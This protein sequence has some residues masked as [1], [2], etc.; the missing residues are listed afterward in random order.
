LNNYKVLEIIE[1]LMSFGA[2]NTPDGHKITPLEWLRFKTTGIILDKAKNYYGHKSRENIYIFSYLPLSIPK[3]TEI[4]SN[5][6]NSTLPNEKTSKHKPRYLC[7]SC[8]CIF[9]NLHEI[10]RE[11]IQPNS[12]VSVNGRPHLFFVGSSS[13][14]V[15]KQS[16]TH[17]KDNS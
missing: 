17:V 13:C 10:C 3:W 8:L 5:L 15:I 4:I 9:S 16:Y 12:A 14:N 7:R 11:E 2:I 1:M 6:S